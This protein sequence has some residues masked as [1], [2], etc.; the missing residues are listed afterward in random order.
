MSQPGSLVTER[1]HDAYLPTD[2]RWERA[3]W[4]RENKCFGKA[5]DKY[6][7]AARSF[8]I[9]LA[10]CRT[11]VEEKKLEARYRGIYRAHEIHR[12]GGTVRYSVEA[13]LLSRA[14]VNQIAELHN[15]TPDAVIWFEKLFFNVCPHLDNELYILH[16]V[17]GDSI[18]H[19]LTDRD[20]DLLWKMLGYACGPVVLRAYMHPFPR[21]RVRDEDQVDGTFTA[22][23]DRQMRKK[24]LI[25]AQTMPAYGNYETI[26]D[27]YHKSQEIEQAKGT[28]T[29]GELAIKQ[30][31]NAMMLGFGR[32]L[33]VGNTPRREPMLD[34]YEQSA[35]ELRADEQTL[36]LLGVETP[37]M[38]EKLN[39]KFADEPCA[40]DKPPQS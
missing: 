5:D 3:R 22:L 36:A 24:A 17:L 13:F 19:G 6:T 4:L 39:W 23:L 29:Q 33:S 20:Y 32:I 7:P 34:K 30:N 38:K 15:T 16:R 26:L 9:A 1:A 18:H 40:G 2:W 28:G 11:L 8:Q 31:I 25:A 21:R 35:M 12:R 10:R 14:P 27:A 37:E